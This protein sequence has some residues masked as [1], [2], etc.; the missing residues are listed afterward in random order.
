M[1]SIERA[2]AIAVSPEFA[3]LPLDHS[4]TV[5]RQA[6]P[7]QVVLDHPNVSHRHAAFEVAERC[8]V[9]R[10]LGGTNGTYVNGALLYGARSLA[11][12]DRIHIGPFEFIFDGTALTRAWR[13]GNVELLAQGISYDVPNRRTSGSLKRILHNA[14]MRIHPSEFV[15]IIGANGSGK[16]TLMNILAGRLFPSEGSVLLNG[17][18]LHA[19]FQALKRDFAFMP[20]QDALHDQLTL[21]QA[22]GY[23]ARLRLPPDTTI[24]QRRVRVHEAAHCV[25]M[26]D[27]LDQRIG[28]FSGGQRKCAGLASEILSR[29]SLLFLD[30]VTSGLDENTDWEIMDLLRRLSDE[31]MTVVLITHTLTSAAE[32]CDKLLCMGGAGHPTFFGTPCE[33]LDFFGVHRLGEV[34][35][36]IDELGA[37]YWC[38]GSEKNVGTTIPSAGVTESRTEPPRANTQRPFQRFAT[39]ESILRQQGCSTL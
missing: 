1:P 26:L 23:T 20:Q 38:V 18:D 14:S 27:R 35:T 6:M 3:R 4:L 9:L 32:F 33:V 11:P 2:D 37:E 29:P 8:V 39:V 25:G 24:A 13:V 31:G 19:N 16:S 10:D 5:G 17:V 21:R 12:G 22:L 34:F 36:R 7:G 30:E 28:A 15:G